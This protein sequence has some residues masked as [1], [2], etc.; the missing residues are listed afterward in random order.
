ME[1]GTKGYCLYDPE[2]K[3]ICVS[4]DVVF[5]E[6][7]T[8]EWSNLNNKVTGRA[9]LFQVP[10]YDGLGFENNGGETGNVQTQDAGIDIEYSRKGEPDTPITER[11]MADTSD[12]TAP[13]KF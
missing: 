1:P 7:K 11:R 13:R 3:K 8:W 9:E 10:G 2:N 4:R 6:N 5:K 12:E